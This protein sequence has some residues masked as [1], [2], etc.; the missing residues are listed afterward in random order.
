MN[1][2][3]SAL[4][5]LVKQAEENNG[6]SV[7]AVAHSKFL[8]VLLSI[9]DDV[10]LLQGATTQQANCCIDVLDMKRDGSFA[11]L[12]QR[13]NLVGGVISNAPED[14][15]LKVPLGRIVRVNEKRHILDLLESS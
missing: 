6:G 9:L 7:I 3:L 12:G 1:R 2:A 8:K 10:P 15:E 11:V 4:S 14:F 13:S 5:Y